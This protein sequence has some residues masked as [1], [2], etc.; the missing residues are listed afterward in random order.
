MLCASFIK[1]AFYGSLEDLLVKSQGLFSSSYDFFTFGAYKAIHTHGKCKQAWNCNSLVLL[2]KVDTEQTLGHTSI[3]FY[4]H[5]SKFIAHFKRVWMIN[6]LIWLTASIT[7]KKSSEN[8]VYMFYFEIFW[9]ILNPASV[10][11]WSNTGQCQQFKTKSVD[12]ALQ[13]NTAT[14]AWVK[15][16]GEN[17]CSIS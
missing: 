13:K 14:V 12:Q 5:S 2:L 1:P 6:H 15:W 17:Q 4:L 3:G 9:I 8:Y 10:K 16:K 7:L 11:K